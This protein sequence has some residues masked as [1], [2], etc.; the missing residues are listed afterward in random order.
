MA[1]GQKYKAPNKGVTHLCSSDTI[2]LIIVPMR[3]AINR[4]HI[5]IYFFNV[6]SIE[7]V[8]DYNSLNILFSL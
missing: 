1:Q 6:V 3:A 8:P 7:D 2:L 4:T 5:D